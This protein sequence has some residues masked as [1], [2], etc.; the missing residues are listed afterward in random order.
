MS[1]RMRWPGLSAPAVLAFWLA[2]APCA[3]AQEGIVDTAVPFVAGGVQ[4]ELLL[5]GPVG[6]DTYQS[7]V[8]DGL[9]YRFDPD[10]YAR[11]GAS[12][13]LD[14]DYWEIVCTVQPVDC[15]GRRGPVTL[16][17]DAEG[18]PTVEIENLN[19]QGSFRLADAGAPALT[20]AELSAPA[21]ATEL[22]AASELRPETEGAPV[23]IGGIGTVARY[24]RWV[25]NGQAP[26]LRADAVPYRPMGRS[27][28][29]P[30]AAPAAGGEG[31]GATPAPIVR[32]EALS[33]E[34]PGATPEP[35]AQSTPA[36]L[37]TAA[38][39]AS[40][41]QSTQNPASAT[42][43]PA[44]PAPARAPPAAPQPSPAPAAGG[45]GDVATPAPI[46]GPEALSLVPPRATAAPDGPAAPTALTTAAG[47]VGAA[48]SK[49][50]PAPATAA[51]SAPAP[52]KAPSAAPKSSSPP[53]AAEPTVTPQA[54]EVATPEA[55]NACAP[56]P[57]SAM[58]TPV[59]SL[60]GLPGVL[61]FTGYLSEPPALK[62]RLQK[63]VFAAGSERLRA[64][65][66]RLLTEEEVE[67]TPGKPRLELYLTNGDATKG[68]DFRVFL[69]LRQEVALARDPSLHLITGTW[70]DGGLS[71]DGWNQ[72]AELATFIYYLDRFIEDYRKANGGTPDQKPAGAPAT[73]APE[74]PP[75]AAAGPVAEGADEARLVLPIQV[76]LREAGY[77]PG[78]ADGIA[79][80]RTR[81][82]ISSFQQQNGM[83]PTGIA[84]A[85]VLER[86]LALK[87]EGPRP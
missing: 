85:E 67:N 15:T 39:L 45:E 68:C 3:L 31:D 4:N 44:A 9:Y 14:E 16:Q 76:A 35:D 69:S 78:P 38:G 77:D 13:R 41:A 82:A 24:I 57:T 79:G 6:W 49:Q 51:S 55:G 26:D 56:L 70:G 5:R 52:A 48:L 36:A 60:H 27:I 42:T 10:G 40:A 18:Y 23:A 53:A 29:P 22:L 59:G 37:A 30:A 65:G 34:P 47:L 80:A 17:V 2:L 21:H 84:G 50:N 46:V 86:L 11:F 62:G 83:E 61:L 1:G 43:A 75:P 54:A 12:E 81:R 71:R 20:L 87:P 72:G 8:A 33:L 64:A 73:V 66:I 63:D 32:S 25:E 19:P 7:G 58:T 28:P 74:S